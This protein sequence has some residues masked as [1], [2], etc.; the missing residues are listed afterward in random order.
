MRTLLLTLLPALLLVPGLTALS[1]ADPAAAAN[2]EIDGS[3]EDNEVRFESNAPMESFDGT[4]STVWGTIELDPG[5]LGDT[6]TLEITCDLATLDTGIDLRN[7][8]M[9]DNHLHTEEHPHAVFRGARVSGASSG[10]LAVGET[11][12]LVLT[13]R[14]TLHGVTRELAAPTELTLRDDGR[15]HLVSRFE[16][17]LSDYDVPRPKFL[18][19]KLDEVQQVS[20]D[21]VAFPTSGE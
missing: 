10:A 12:S 11:V 9:R 3:N 19:L 17:N 6:L 15:L 20:V 5:A 4:T 21:V 14:L 18:M 16:V 13:G 7:Q 1:T 8:H 2:Y